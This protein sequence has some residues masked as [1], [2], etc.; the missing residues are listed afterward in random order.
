MFRCT[1]FHPSLCF[2][3]LFRSLR[4]YIWSFFGRIDHDYMLVCKGFLPYSLVT[5]IKFNPKIGMFLT[6]KILKRRKQVKALDFSR[7]EVLTSGQLH[8]YLRIAKQVSEICLDYCFS[9]TRMP[10]RPLNFISTEHCWKMFMSD[11]EDISFEQ[12]KDI[13]AYGMYYGRTD[14]S[15]CEFLSNLTGCNLYDLC[16]IQAKIKSLPTFS[17]HTRPALDFS[18]AFSSYI[19]FPEP[20]KVE[21]MVSSTFESVNTDDGLF[22]QNKFDIAFASFV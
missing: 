4:K 12:F 13:V 11:G 5:A 2:P 9:I 20:A 6:E 3:L 15:V 17:C 22:V 10:E 8:R 18:C 7:N 14:D 16:E 21:L 19:T 1:V